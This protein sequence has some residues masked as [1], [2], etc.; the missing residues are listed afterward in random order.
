MLFCKNILL[1]LLTLSF[2]MPMGYAQENTEHVSSDSLQMIGRGLQSRGN[3]E[4]LA[5]AC[6]SANCDTLRFVHIQGQEAI[7]IG[8]SIILP[9][10]PSPEL[11]AEA[12]GILITQYFA[13][14]QT[15]TSRK[16]IAEHA[17]FTFLLTLGVGL[18]FLFTGPI[19]GTAAIITGLKVGGSMLSVTM[20]GFQ[21]NFYQYY[22]GT[23]EE[24]KLTDQT[25][26]NWSVKP[27]TVS[28]NTFNSMVDQITNGK[29]SWFNTRAQKEVPNNLIR[30]IDHK[31]DQLSV[32]GVQFFKNSWE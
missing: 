1:A 2:M 19:T 30:K 25:G 3:Q 15:A 22:Q 24:V 16:K 27:K 28:P 20:L 9:E 12:L 32:K 5:L 13:T 10:A 7:F 11:K 26:W 31:K 6:Y 4:F 8:D 29:G 17:E 14:H 21:P 18:I 23:N